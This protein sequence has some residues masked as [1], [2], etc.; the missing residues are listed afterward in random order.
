MTTK[1]LAT[2]AALTML[3]TAVS[4]ANAYD[5]VT[6]K[7][8]SVTITSCGSGKTYSQCRSYMSGSVVKTSCR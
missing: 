2:F 6:R 1:L 3:T 5:C 7:S 8:G 4:T